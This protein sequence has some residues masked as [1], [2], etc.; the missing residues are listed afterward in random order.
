MRRLTIPLIVLV[1]IISAAGAA[2]AAH[3]QAC[4]GPE[5][6]PCQNGLTCKTAVGYRGFCEPLQ[7]VRSQPNT[8]ETRSQP[9]T[10]GSNVTLSNPLKGGSSLESF[11]LNILDFVINIG[12]IIV[13][14]MLVYVGFK[15]VTAQGEPGK[16][17]EAR[18]MLLWTVIG[19]LV[20]LGSKAIALG[21]EATV[22]AL[23]SG[24]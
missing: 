24:G 13:V 2:P 22:K 20:L 6:P 9:N 1:F 19:A 3:A 16:I 12:S 10:T 8:F 4:G 5:D 21:V 14:L 18:E 11:L 23:S 7:D 17:S 15:F